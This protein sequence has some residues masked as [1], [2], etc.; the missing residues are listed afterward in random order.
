[1]HNQAPCRKLQA[2]CFGPFVIYA[3]GVQQYTVGGKVC[4][5]FLAGD[6]CGNKGQHDV[7]LP[8][9]RSDA[10]ESVNFLV[11]IPFQ[12]FSSIYGAHLK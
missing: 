10:N 9:R 6:D 2:F 5:Q 1:M 11:Y 3:R 4:V 12:H 7:E 8:T